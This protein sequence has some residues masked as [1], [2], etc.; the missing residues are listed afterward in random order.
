MNARLKYSRLI[1]ATAA[2]FIVA[3]SM[4]GCAELA[5]VS[6]VGTLVNGPV[7]DYNR[8]TETN[9]QTFQHPVQ[10]VYKT[11]VAVVERDGR[12]I[13]SNDSDAH[14]LRVSYPFSW[15]HNNWGGVI[16][17][18]CSLTEPVDGAPETVVQVTGGARDALFRIRTLGAAILKDLG[19][20]LAR[21][22]RGD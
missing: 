7:P 20:E 19:D 16:A 12:K 14:K 21:Q 17:I 6:S 5:L 10:M 18:T 8:E 2:I 4:S 9:R 3:V 1:G 22:A 13:V 11:L 15:L